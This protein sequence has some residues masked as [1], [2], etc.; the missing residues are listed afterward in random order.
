MKSID[1]TY[2]SNEQLNIIN[3]I[4]DGNNVITDA[5]PGS[6]KSTTVLHLANILTDKSFLQLTYN[7]QLKLEIRT[8]VKKYKIRNLEIHS[9][10]SLV[11]KYYDNDTFNNEHLNI[12]LD[13]NKSLILHPYFDIIIIDE[14]QDMTILYY[15]LILKFLKDYGRKDILIL[16]LGDKQQVLYKFKGADPKF[17]TYADKIFNNCTSFLKLPLNRSYRLTEPNAWFIND[18]MLGDNRISTN[19]PG[20]PVDYI[21]HNIFNV[22][23]LL[24][25][26]I[27]Q[28]LREGYKPDDIF[29]LSYSHKSSKAPCKKLEHLL[30]EHGIPCYI[31][32]NDEAR[33]DEDI[34][35]DK[36]VFTTF[37]QSKGRERKMVI[38][39]GFD[40]GYFNF[41]DKDNKN[42]YECP[43]Q[44]LVACSRSLEY[45]AVIQHNRNKPL[46]FLK[47]DIN[48]LNNHKYC[49]VIGYNNTYRT[50]IPQP[51]PKNNI[52]KT[53]VVNIVSHLSDE[54]ITILKQ[55]LDCL[56]KCVNYEGKSIEIPHKIYQDNGRCEEVSDING[57]A[58]PMMWEHLH[59]N[60]IS[61]T[62]YIMRTEDKF[63]LSYLNE[64]NILC[65]SIEDYLKYA[66]FIISY[67]KK[68]HSKLAQLTTYDWI[69]DDIV[70]VCLDNL[71]KHVNKKIHMEVSIEDLNMGNKFIYNCEYGKIIIGA[72]I[73]A[74][75]KHTIWEFKCVDSLNIEHKLQL[76][77]YCWIWNKCLK[78]THGS[79]KF[80]L[81]NIRNEVIFE[82]DANSYLIDDVV[83]TILNYKYGKKF[84]INDTEFLNKCIK[85][86]NKY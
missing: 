11:K 62:N 82:L 35:K 38:V 47:K 46:P 25:E 50:I 20:I 22:H 73:D 23:K 26:I 24:I 1:S 3:A 34:I 32:T 80:L 48:F 5:V 29:I 67:D 45:L 63:Y 59:K 71:N 64:I 7:S 16:I 54:C 33:I 42:I 36:V 58:I 51:L 70:K 30:V 72:R 18:V 37:H 74:I 65:D 75:D 83:N 69:S 40:V 44:L 84:D 13:I 61:I 6:G 85:V 57:I 78:E 4:K 52:I 28:K 77:I 19:K 15:E 43:P 17:I 8:K 27:I 41:F 60:K 21:I 56:F 9:Y 2:P 55:S 49:N 39:Y 86:S 14:M 81:M 53:S 68:V 79:R 76:I 12:V 66:N 10:N 31:S